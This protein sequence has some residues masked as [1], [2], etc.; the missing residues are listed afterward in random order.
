[1]LWELLRSVGSLVISLKKTFNNIKVSLDNITSL[2]ALAY[3]FCT[4]DSIQKLAR[5]RRKFVPSCKSEIHSFI[6]SLA[7]LGLENGASQQRSHQ[8]SAL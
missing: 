8:C 3:G 1:M 2:V 7:R 6:K 4:K 5:D